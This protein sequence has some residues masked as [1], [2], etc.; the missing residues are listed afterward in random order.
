MQDGNGQTIVAQ[1]AD[2]AVAVERV[3]LEQSECRSFRSLTQSLPR[4]VEERLD[5]LADIHR[6]SASLTLSKLRDLLKHM[7]D[8]ERGLSRIGFGRA[9]PNELLRV[10]EAFRRIGN[11]FADVDS[12]DEDG[13]GDGDDD[14]GPIKTGAGGGLKSTL[15]KSVVKELPKVKQTADELL[16]EI[17][18]KRARDND[19]E[20]LFVDED[21]YPDLKVCAA[22]RD[23]KRFADI[24]A[25][26]NAKPVSRGRSRTCRA[27]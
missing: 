22:F 7:P 2:E 8:L 18:A 14:D 19:K 15:L 23:S 16:T 11:V 1:V 24:S 9:T 12:P 5:A 27:S 13:A 6:L 26:R 10:L 17:D 3:C 20:E 25:R 4:L 21:K